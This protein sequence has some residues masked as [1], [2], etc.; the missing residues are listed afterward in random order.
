MII[1]I[2]RLNI[3]TGPLVNI[4]GGGGGE[5][6]SG[7]IRS[8][9]YLKKQ[10]EA[11][12]GKHNKP[13]TEEHKRKISLAISG[14][15]NPNFGRCMSDEQKIKISRA[16]KGT[17]SPQ[18]G[19]T[20]EELYGK[21]RALELKIKNSESHKGLQA[22][23]NNPNYGKRGKNNPNFGKH[24]RWH[25]SEET[26]KKFSFIRRGIPSYKK[27]KTVEELYGKEKA[28]ELR[29]KF[30]EIRFNYWKNKKRSLCA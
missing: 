14:K 3:K 4:V 9:E 30:T 19:K 11:Q 20:V 29:K 2:G 27:G 25:W 8:E 17:I 10:S 22:G 23:K 1:V 7:Y 26:K 13:L 18:R 15:N 21:K 5:V 16:K 6:G 28:K 24:G 12:K